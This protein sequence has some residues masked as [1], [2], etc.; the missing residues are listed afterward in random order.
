MRILLSVLRDLGA[1][2]SPFNS[3]LMIQGLE[4]LTLR[5]KEHSQNAQ[6]IATFLENH[7]NVK[8]VNYPGLKNDTNYNRA[9]LYLKG[10]CSGLL[11]FE[12]QDLEKAKYIVDN[13]PQNI[14]DNFI[15]A[16]PMTGTEKFGPKAAIDSLS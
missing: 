14:R 2:A 6:K 5:I 10:G 12:V 9:K 8:K 4:T 3:W 13:I 16:H 7:K 15:P 11:S 1:T